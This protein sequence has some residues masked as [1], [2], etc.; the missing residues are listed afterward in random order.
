MKDLTK[1]LM[2]LTETAFWEPKLA[3]LDEL[4]GKN[5]FLEL[6]VNQE[7]N[8]VGPCPQVPNY[9]HVGNV[10]TNSGVLPPHTTYDDD[11]SQIL[12]SFTWNLCLQESV[13]H[14]NLFFTRNRIRGIDAWG[15]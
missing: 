12:T 9:L 11:D 2:T 1:F 5:R 10:L 14:R 13:P 3:F 7:W 6:S 15:P 4:W 8:Q